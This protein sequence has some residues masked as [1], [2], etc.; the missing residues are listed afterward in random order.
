VNYLLYVMK[1]AYREF[2]TRVGTVGG[3][4]GEKREVILAAIRRVGREF[5]VADLQTECPGVSVD[6]IRHVLK[7]LRDRDEVECRG[8]GRSAR[9]HQTRK[10]GN[11]S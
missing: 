4:R 2:E 1:E 6:M 8:R 7:E 9:W 5:S 3:R 10:F 11:K